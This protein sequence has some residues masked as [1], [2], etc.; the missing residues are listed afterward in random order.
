MSKFVGTGPSSRK[1][2]NYQ[3]TVPQ[4]LRNTAVVDRMTVVVYY[5]NIA[6]T[7]K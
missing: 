5:E 7:L 2:R 3:A 1:K 4:R 6:E